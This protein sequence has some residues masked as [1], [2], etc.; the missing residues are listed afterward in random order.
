MLDVKDEIPKWKER[1]KLL[2]S[3]ERSTDPARLSALGQLCLQKGYVQDAFEYFRGAK[4]NEGL[5]KI[6]ELALD[7]GDSFLLDSLEKATQP[8][9]TDVWNQIGY[10]AFD[11]GKYRF[12]RKAFERTANELMLA[13]IRATLGEPEP[14]SG[15]D[16]D[17]QAA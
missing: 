16:D 15:S 2:Y 7:E 9:S 4:S 3:R 13:K 5:Q 11:L 12:A 6:K 1:Q 14:Q 17:P 10:R 8:F